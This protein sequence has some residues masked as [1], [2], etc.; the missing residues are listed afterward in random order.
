MA[1]TWGFHWWLLVARC[2]GFALGSLLAVLFLD[3][4]WVE[5]R[6]NKILM[7][8]GLTAL[9]SLG[10]IGTTVP[11]TNEMDFEVEMSLWPSLMILSFNLFFFAIVGLILCQTG[12]SILRILRTPYPPISRYGSAMGFISITHW[13]TLPSSD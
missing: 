7:G 8:L 13:Y 4:S 11:V 3:R 1:R 2:D 9:V 5:S 6:K 12:H 10:A